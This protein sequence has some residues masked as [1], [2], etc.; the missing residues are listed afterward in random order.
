MLNRDKEQQFRDQEQHLRD[1]VRA[2]S[3]IQSELID[4]LSFK[5]AHEGH[6]QASLFLRV[7]GLLASTGF[8]LW[9]AA[10]LFPHEKGR[11]DEYLKHVETFV[12][13]IVSDNAIAF[14]DDKNTWSLWH[15]IGVSRSSLLEAALLLKSSLNSAQ[16][17]K[18]QA[19][20]LDAPSLQDTAARQWDEL[21]DLMQHLRK[22]CAEEIK[23]IKSMRPILRTK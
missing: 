14:S 1:M 17:E 2:R 6:L 3:K 16:L 8:S 18:I 12:T 22:V 4:L 23:T 21:F 13:K 11:H 5:H 19:T 15:Y 9:R 10:F 20:L 7:I